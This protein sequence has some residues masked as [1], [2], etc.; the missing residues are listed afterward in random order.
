MWTHCT[1]HVRVYIWAHYTVY[2]TC[3]YMHDI[4]RYVCVC[5]TTCTP[6]CIVITYTLTYRSCACLSSYIHIMYK[7]IIHTYTSNFI[8]STKTTW[9]TDKKYKMYI[10]WLCMCTHVCIH[11]YKYTH[12]PCNVFAYIR[13]NQNKSLRWLCMRPYIGAYV[14]TTTH[15]HF[16]MCSYA[17]T[18]VPNINSFTLVLIMQ[19]AMTD[20]STSK[21]MNVA[22][23]P[24]S[25]YNMHIHVYTYHGL[26]HF[27]W[28][29][30]PM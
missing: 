21:Y 17:Y 13:T 30:M 6:T 28:T 24:H 25:R 23:V 11:T 5:T 10:W 15:I 16:A 7:L 12:T 9:R 22:N 19:S 26:P 4:G 1:V 18:H 29:R 2:G 14:H 8:N 27:Q 20:E 3:V